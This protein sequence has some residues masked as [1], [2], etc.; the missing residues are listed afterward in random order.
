MEPIYISNFIPVENA[1][2]Y[3]EI[4]MNEVHWLEVQANRK[5]CFMAS[6]PVQYAYGNFHGSPIRPY[7]S[8]DYHPAVMYL[9]HKLNAGYLTDYNVCFLNRYDDASKSLGWHAD[10]S[11]EMNLDHP[12]AVI[13][14]G[15]EREI[16]WRPKEQ[17]GEVPP[18]QRR[19]LASGSLFIMPA[20]FQKDYYHRIPKGSS[21]KE[22]R[23]SLTFRNYK[24][25][26]DTNANHV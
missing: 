20:G 6:K 23:I 3:Y 19:L 12:I 7:Q 16:W 26:G 24:E 14:L 15:A 17:K 8:T 21:P 11:P 4:L 1:Q 25:A 9:Q 5:E 2:D 10:D 18:E 22:P 13:S